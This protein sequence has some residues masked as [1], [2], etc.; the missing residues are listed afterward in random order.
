MTQPVTLLPLF[1]LLMALLWATALPGRAPAL[2]ALACALALAWAW[3]REGTAQ[4]AALARKLADL[5]TRAASQ[6][7]E[8]ARSD[9]ARRAAERER[10]AAEER[11]VIALR[12]SQD[13][14][15]EWDLA[16]DAVQLS[17]RWK[18]LLGFDAREI[19]DDKGGWLG[20]VHG[21]DRARF[22][23]ALARHLDGASA[24]FDESLRLVAKDGRA[25]HVL[26][27]AV[28][29]RDENGRAYRMVGLDT[30]VSP[31][32]R[33]QTILEAVAA[34]TADAHG[35]RFF[36]ALVEHFARALEVDRA[37]ITECADHPTT[38][39]RT[40]AAW[41]AQAGHV[42]NFEYALEGTPCA[43]VVGDARTCFH[44]S[45]LAARFPRERGFESFLGLPIVGSDGRLLGHL[46]FFDRRPR[47]EE[48]LVDA[49]YR[50]FTGRAACEIERLRALGRTQG[51][52][53]ASIE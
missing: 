43:E 15:W 2:A 47:G 40:L 53:V 38:R 12:G 52:A 3:R 19:S 34:G 36:A 22:E 42:P 16:S 10:R 14:F 8:L 48:L 49:I 51:A 1:G 5:E 18:S 37:F 30:D 20:R 29:I 46:A 25:V 13:G 26:T 31:L 6:H 27:R 32:R 45:G 24:R 33:L 39:V 44:P 11:T 35:D 21:D 50:I 7:A 4:R 23:H 17:P 9:E 28:A 41:T